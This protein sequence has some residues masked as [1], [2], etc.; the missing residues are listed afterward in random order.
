MISAAA[1]QAI[2]GASGSRRINPE[3]EEEGSGM[4]GLLAKVARKSLRRS[5]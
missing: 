5:Y 3:E 4:K 1:A 2:R